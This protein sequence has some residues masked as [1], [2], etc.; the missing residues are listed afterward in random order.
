MALAEQGFIAYAKNLLPKLNQFGEMVFDREKV[1]NFLPILSEIVELYPYMQY[2][3]YFNA[4]LHLAI[5]EKENA[6]EIF[7]PFAKK[8]QNDF[9]VWVILSE[10]YSNDDEK[11]Y[12]CYCKALSCHSPEDMLVKLRQKMASILISKKL[13]NEAKTEIVLLVKSRTNNDFKIPNEVINWQETD[14]YKNAIALNSNIE[15]YKHHTTIAESM[16]YTDIVEESIIVE[17]VNTDKKIL[18]F[19]AS[20]TKFG[21]FK[22][23][24]F[25]SDI[26]IGD[27]LS[28]RFKNKSKEGMDQLYT[29]IKVEDED[30]K[31]LFIKEING[32]V[33]KSTDKPFGFIDDVFISPYLVTKYKLTN[34]MEYSGKAIKSFNQEKKL[35]GWKLF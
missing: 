7:L 27:V 16:L 29:A 12:S 35:W 13:Y 24:R 3:A 6:L 17:F 25:F 1:T 32:V 20:E 33:K 14:W 11:V 5:G 8:K 30:F 21:F 28:V 23:D 26:K 15:L 34:G 9:W 10:I 31:N 19:I 22:Y 18:N 4:K 2:P